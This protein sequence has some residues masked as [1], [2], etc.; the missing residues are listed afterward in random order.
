MALA[1]N[2][3]IKSKM[4]KDL[5]ERLVGKGEY[6]DAQNINVS[7]SEGDDVGSVEN[8]LGNELTANL[9]TSTIYD[10]KQVIGQYV[11]QSKERGFFYITDHFDN[12]S[13]RLSNPTHKGSTCLIVMRDFINNTTHTLVSGMF[14]NFSITHPI[15]NIDLI[16]DLLFW[17]DDR[18]QPRRINVDKAL[19]SSTYYTTEDNISVA[20][21]NP[22]N[23]ISLVNEFTVTVTG[24]TLTGPG[25]FTLSNADY[26]KIKQGQFVKMPNTNTQ[27]TPCVIQSTSNSAKSF[28]LNQDYDQTNPAATTITILETGSKNVSDRFTEATVF[29]TAAA[30]STVSGIIQFTVSNLSGT[31][32][33]SMRIFNSR[34]KSVITIIDLPGYVAGDNSATVK[35]TGGGLNEMEEAFQKFPPSQGNYN[36]LVYFADSNSQY[37]SNFS[38]DKEYLR[39]KFVRFSYRFKFEDGEYSLIAPFTSPAFVP[40]QNGHIVD[41]NQLYDGSTANTSQQNV[42]RGYENIARSTV[43]DFFE[44][45][46]NV[47]DLNIQMPFAVNTLYDKLKVEEI[48]I[49][50]KESDTLA[51]RVLETIQKTDTRITSNSTAILTYNY[52][53]NEPFKPV[54]EA[55]VVRVFDRVPIRAK[56]QSVTGNRVVYGNFLNKHTP[57]EFLSYNTEI[58]A[59]LNSREDSSGVPKGVAD[60]LVKHPTAS[61][62]QN[63]TYQVGVILVDRYGRQTD[64]ILSDADSNSFTY[65]GG[66]YGGDTIFYPY[67]S[68]GRAQ[69][70]PITRWFGDSLKVLFR[71]V[72]P[73]SV[74]YADGYPGIYKP[75]NYTVVASN[76][77][78]GTS[79]NATGFEQDPEK[80][81]IITIGGVDHVVISTI[82]SYPTYPLVPV[83]NLTLNSSVSVTAGTAYNVV[84]KANPLGFYTYKIVIKQLQQEYYNSYLGNVIQGGFKNQKDSTG[85]LLEQGLF[86]T[87]LAYASLFGSNINKIPADLAETEPNQQLFTPNTTKLYTRVQSTIPIGSSTTITNNLFVGNNTVSKSNPFVTGVYSAKLTDLKALDLAASTP[88]PGIG[89]LNAQQDPIGFK[90][91]TNGSVLGVPVVNPAYV[92]TSFIS[93]DLRLNVMEVDPPKSNIEIY[94]ETACSGLVREL[95]NLI[96]TGTGA[97]GTAPDPPSSDDGVSS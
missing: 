83:C 88:L 84:G 28:T 79:F 87:S 67:F 38:G 27:V 89:F 50:Y 29:G 73:N 13:D 69:V 81:D 71:S 82:F 61:V 32:Y 16:E 23:A 80:G 43:V 59:K 93:T 31:I 15:L 66:S 68:T 49:L 45:S 3:F 24:G 63:R 64:V 37:L 53:S 35:T 2:I 76:N 74:V 90:I 85:T 72:I 33:P 30:P 4:N 95:N 20:K 70:T 22:Y 26:A 51:I 11:D 34:T 97:S 25:P 58:S 92:N 54:T 46:V 6:R 78:T 65:A 8:L 14:L 75:G 39:D 91:N 42:E 60:L 77:V 7:R 40:K 12:S 62:K 36:A 9:T 10:N 18:N 41:I 96:L 86:R 1:K 94:Y 19:S 17:T 47:V 55:Q 48:D 52:N 57:P 21:Y 5:D 44:N 56:T